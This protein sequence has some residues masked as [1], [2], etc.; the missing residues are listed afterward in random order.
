MHVFRKV[1]EPIRHGLDNEKRWHGPDQGLIA[2]WERGREL[3]VESPAVADQ[4]RMGWLVTLPW[5]GGVDQA[6]KARQKFGTLRYLAMWQGLRGESLDIDTDAE[7]RLRC[8]KTHVTV[9]YTNDL[10]KYG[11]PD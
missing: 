7:I 4:A 9:V 10:S 8:T 3:S 5:K 11:G 1:A 6:L 2:A